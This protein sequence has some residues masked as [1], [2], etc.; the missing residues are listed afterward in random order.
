MLQ[1]QFG[2]FSD[3][4]GYQ[5]EGGRGDVRRHF[6][7]AGA[8]RV[9]AFDGGGVAVHFHRVAE[10]LQHALGVVAGRR[11]LGHRGR[12]FGI[13]ARQQQAGLHLGAG[14]RHVVVHAGQAL[15]ALDR[16]RRAALRTG[17]DHRAHLAQRLGHAIHR[18]LGQ[19]RV[20][21]Q[22]GVERLRGEQA[23]EQAHRSAR[24][25]HVQRAGRGLEAVQA[26]AVHGDAAVVRAFDDH[27]HVAERL[28]GGQGVLAFEE[29][30][31]LGGT[32]GQRAEHD[33][34]VGDG[35]V[36]RNAD[37]SVQAA[38][39][40][41]QENQV[42]GMHG[43]HIGP[44]GQNFAEM[45]TGDAGAGEH[46][47][48]SMPVSMIDR[49]AQTIEVAA[50]AVENAQHRLAVGEEDVV[51]HHRIAAGDAGEIA[52]ATGS[53]AEDLEVLALVGQRVDQA[54]GQQVRQVAGGGEHL[55]V[56]L[57]GHVLDVGTQRPPQAV[58]QR[59]RRRLGLG[60]RGEDH[61]V[62]AVQLAVGRLHAALLGAGDRVAGYEA[63]D[64]RTEHLARGA[65]HVALGA[66]GV[67]EH[68][69]AQLEAGQLRQHLLHGQDRHRQHDHL[70]ADAGRGQLAF[71]AVDHA[72]LH[73]QAA[74]LG[75]QIDAHHLAAQAQLA[76]AL[77]EGAADQA[78]TDHHQAADQRLR[79]AFSHDR[80]PGSA[81]RGSGRFPP[82]CRST[83]A[84]RSACRSRPPD[85]RSRRAPADPG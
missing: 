8:E 20:A 17:L 6:D 54:E 78:E 2:A 83:R 85:G 14:H 76:Q 59:Q 29:A 74:R 3:A 11:R 48:Q 65:H 56:V 66:A 55:V 44:T 34:A 33:R 25:A 21:G 26:D 30:F 50:E 39:R 36:A 71:A 7:A 81:P 24:V 69:G 61:L 51:P 42:V 19:R 13:Q 57:D 32:L 45:L 27:A 82:R 15:T 62:A 41:G 64:A 18:P 22:H 58:D 49:L 79:L 53:V 5:E 4:A 43:V 9:A 10:A 80:A 75:V 23:G 73:R 38:A 70:G 67:G 60:Q 35:L 77:G 31:H 16:Q 52:K 40:L 12:A 84:G 1:Q 37:P 28:D 46:A 72:Q 63:G 68:R 47:Q